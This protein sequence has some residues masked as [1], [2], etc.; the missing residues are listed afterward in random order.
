MRNIVFA[1]VL[2]V[3]APLLIAQQ[4][5]NNDSVIKLCKAGLS[6]D[7]IV[8]TITASPGN[9]DT[10]A[11]GLIA[12]KAA[13]ASDKVVAAIVSKASAPVVAVAANPPVQ[14]ATDPDDPMT[15]HDPGVYLMTTGHDGKSKML[16]IDRAGAGNEKTSGVLTHAFTY[17]IVKAKMKAELPGPRATVRSQDARPV[18]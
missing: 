13:G 18:F 7:L 8:S 4:A 1:F 12:L 6:D 9:Y 15:P 10:S 2:V 16:F 3:F 14:A 11:D 5:M 17:G